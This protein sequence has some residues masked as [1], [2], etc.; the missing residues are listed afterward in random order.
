MT[1]LKQKLSKY[2][3]DHKLNPNSFG[4]KADISPGIITNIM[5]SDST[6]PTI[7]TALKIAKIMNCSLGK[8]GIRTEKV[9]Q[10]S[11]TG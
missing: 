10:H 11:F 2:I 5:S 9:Q 4:R 6:N 8:N 3:V 7:E 1:A